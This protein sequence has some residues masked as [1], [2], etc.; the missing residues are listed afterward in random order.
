MLIFRYCFFL[1]P[2]AAVFCCF[3]CTS[4]TPKT[5]EVSAVDSLTQRLD[6]IGFEPYVQTLIKNGSLLNFELIGKSEGEGS[7]LLK[8]SLYYAMS[9]ADWFMYGIAWAY[10][11]D[12]YTFYTRK[13]AGKDLENFFKNHIPDY[14]VHLYTIPS[15]L[16]G[17]VKHVLDSIKVIKP[18]LNYSEDVL[19]CGGTNMLIFDGHKFFYL[20]GNYGQPTKQFLERLAPIYDKYFKAYYKKRKKKK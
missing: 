11:S 12:N 7:K 4:G 15:S 14:S 10:G 6:S 2:L 18:V 3:S 5:A 16:E 1:L 9:S 19:V 20:S 8:D 17:I 13:E